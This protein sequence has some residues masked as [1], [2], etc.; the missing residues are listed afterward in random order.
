MKENKK[1]VVVLVQR[2][3]T[4][5]KT[6]PARTSSIFPAERDHLGMCPTKDDILFV[7]DII[8]ISL[9]KVTVW[10]RPVIPRVTRGLAYSPR[11]W[12]IGC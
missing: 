11:I 10:G 7:L 8:I 5:H 2:K 12:L 4:H 1:F 9:T 3:Q 6:L